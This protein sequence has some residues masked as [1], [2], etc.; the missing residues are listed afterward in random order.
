M[1]MKPYGLIS[2]HKICQCDLCG[3]R[4]KLKQYKASE[5]QKAKKDIRSELDAKK[6]DV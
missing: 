2:L 5:R 4:R 1:I 6:T 3:K